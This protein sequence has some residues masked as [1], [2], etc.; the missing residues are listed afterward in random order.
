MTFILMLVFLCGSAS[1]ATLTV[2]DSEGKQYKTIQNA[3]NAAKTGDTI[4]V[5]AGNYPE[6]VQ[7]NDKDLIFQ[8]EKTST[9]Y[10]YPSL[11]GFKFGWTADSSK[12]GSGD[13]NGFKIT[14]DGIGYGVAGG[15]IVRNNFFYNCGVGAGGGS[16]S[17][18]TI[19]NNK[20]SENYDYDGVY[21]QECYDNSITGNTFTKAKNGIVLRWGATCTAITKNTFDSCE[22]AFLSGYKPSILTGN[23]YKNNKVN[24]KIVEDF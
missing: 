16:C 23:T 10:K 24:I 1:A 17:G 3:V 7:V 21:L 22:V 13:I 6:T 5:Y 4:Y 11:Y 19:I 14:K 15:N 18:N 2:D 20:F 12:I 8:G 9:C